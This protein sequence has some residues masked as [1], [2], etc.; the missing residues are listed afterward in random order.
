MRASR[1]PHSAPASGRGVVL[2]RPRRPCARAR[3]RTASAHG[4]LRPERAADAAEGGERLVEPRALGFGGRPHSR[5]KRPATSSR[6]AASPARVPLR[7]SSA[8]RTN[9]RNSGAGRCGRDLNSGWYWE[10]TKYGWSGSSMIS[11]RRSSGD[12]PEMTRPAALEPLAQEVVDLVAMAVALVDDG[13]AV[14]LARLRALVE[15]DRVGAEAHR[16]AHVVDLLLLGQQVDHGVRRLGVELR[17]VGA[18]H[19]DD[20]AREVGHRHLHA[21]AHAQVRDLV[22]AGDPRG[23]DLALD[24]ADAEAAGDEDAVGLLEPCADLRVVQRLGVH[25]VDV[26]AAAVLEAGVAQRLDDGQVGVLELHVLADERDA[27]GRLGGRLRGRAH[28]ALPLLELGLAAPPCRSGRGSCRR[29]PRRGS[30]AA[31]CRC[32]RRR[33][34]R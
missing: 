14:D 30:R 10:A 7:Y 22:V 20:V 15:L 19:A 4:L 32:C 23:G 18:V 34:R 2:R 11:T 6:L 16:A 25:P 26:D 27:H 1:L 28:E 24:P 29:R 12:V 13:L 9:S 8:A 17:R 5:P 33:A 21:E 3:A 31:P